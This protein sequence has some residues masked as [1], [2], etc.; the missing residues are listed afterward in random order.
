MRCSPLQMY[1]INGRSALGY[2][3]GEFAFFPKKLLK[4]LSVR[5]KLYANKLAE[6]EKE[7]TGGD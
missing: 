7:M 3:F 5:Q 4:N 1:F 6:K 2:F